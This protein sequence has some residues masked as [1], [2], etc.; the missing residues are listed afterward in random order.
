MR[1]AAILRERSVRLGR[2]LDR[3]EGP[4]HR[5]EP[6]LRLRQAEFGIGQV[7][8]RAFVRG[9]ADEHR[10]VHLLAVLGVQ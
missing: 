7:R 4:D 5:V 8:H 1:H 10:E 6:A 3:R 9:K 2:R